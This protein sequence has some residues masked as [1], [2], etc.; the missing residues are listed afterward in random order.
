MKTFKEFL[1][2]KIE[3][4]DIFT[5]TGTSRKTPFIKNPNFNEFINFIGRHEEMWGGMLDSKG[6][7]YF[8][9]SDFA[10]H[11]DVIKGL[12]IDVH[13]KHHFRF[14]V[15]SLKWIIWIPSPSATFQSIMGIKKLNKMV[16]DKKRP[17][18]VANP[19]SDRIFVDGKKMTIF[20]FQKLSGTD[21]VL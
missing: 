16:S 18:V 10:L 8:F 6:D 3:M 21:F 5:S 9:S 14:E 17:F 13:R 12:G 11:L 2:E 19:K 7:L 15:E 4:V 20:D 1:L